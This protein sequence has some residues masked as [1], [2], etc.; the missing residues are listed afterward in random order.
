M[1]TRPYSDLYGLVEA[2]CGCTFAAQ[3]AVRVKYFIN[4][5]AQR[6]YAESEYWPRFYV[7]G[8]ERNVSD[9]GLLPDE[10][11][12]LNDIGTVLRIHAS[13]PFLTSFA[14]EYGDFYKG[15][16]GTQI[17]GYSANKSSADMVVSGAI[18][19]E[20]LGVY[21]FQGQ[22]TDDDFS[23]TV[24]NI[25]TLGGGSVTQDAVGYTVTAPPTG[26]FAI[27]SIREFFGWALF[28]YLD[29]A[30]IS[31]SKYWSNVATPETPDGLTLSPGTGASGDALVN[32]QSA[33]AFV[34]YKA[35]LSATY[36]DAD[37]DTADVPEE[38]FEY[39]AHGAYSDFLRNDQQQDR[40][41]LA[42][43]E[44][45]E[46]LMAQLEKIGRQNGSS[47]FTRIVTPGNSQW[48]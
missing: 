43:Q 6:A 4:R 15:A 7:V 30:L 39:M 5:R 37:G 13:A 21:E 40:A 9:A 44:A 10:Q 34:T 28:P 26:Y 29:G 17:T 18:D 33:S 32:A 23:E 14:A 41:A 3:E 46:I 22:F 1:N 31:A 12:G 38:W 36:G 48:R 47:A 27:L 24:T 16:S 25:Y 45:N 8:E 2:L 35:A 20:F 11:T 42:E 19:D